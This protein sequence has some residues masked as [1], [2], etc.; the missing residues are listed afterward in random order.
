MTP[1]S[2]VLE[3]QQIFKR[4]CD[5]AEE[6]GLPK[7]L[8]D[9]AGQVRFTSRHD[10][11]YFPI[12]FKETETTAALKAIEGSVACLL[13]DLR[14][15]KREREINVSLQ[16]TTNFLFQTYLATVDGLGKLDPAIK[17]K[18]KDTDYLRAQSEP[19]RRMSANLYETK[20][21]GEY[22]HIHG[23]LEATTTLN[24][25]GL[26]SSR[27]DLTDHND[28]VS[29]IEPA[30]QKFTIEELEQMNASKRQA[31]VPAL[32]HEDFLKSRHVG[33]H[34]AFLPC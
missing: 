16:K 25:L 27:P 10:R 31:G 32:K 23:S 2:P 9:V 17:K 14:H 13:A 19:Y 12:P 26:E 30:V 1:Y 4:L 28:I 15:G 7:N 5:Q 33:N 18:L 24:M 11:I 20:R 3:A 21:A 34:L 29:I 6:L 22:Y 8:Q